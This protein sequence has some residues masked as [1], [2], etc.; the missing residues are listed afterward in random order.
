[1]RDRVG[2]RGAA[3]LFFAL[4]DLVY[5]GSLGWAPSSVR[6]TPAYVWLTGYLP[7]WAWAGLWAGVGLLC[8]VQAFQRADRVAFACASLLKVLW[9]VLHVAGWL[10]D[11]VPRGYVSAVIWLARA[12]R[13]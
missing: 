13:R 9:G 2:R 8:L 12:R 5:A 7:L 11:V 6:S 10:L 3:L 4:L 1:V